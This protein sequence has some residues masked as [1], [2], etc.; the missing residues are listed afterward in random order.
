MRKSLR[1]WAEEQFAAVRHPSDAYARRDGRER[2]CLFAISGPDLG[3][4]V[5]G[6]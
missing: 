2:V 3:A 6:D 5:N 1:S 4:R